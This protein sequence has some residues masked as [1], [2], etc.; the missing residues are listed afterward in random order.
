MPGSAQ[1]YVNGVAVAGALLLLMA[2]AEWPGHAESDFRQWVPYLL[3]AAFTSTL[4]VR[5]PGLAGSASP[6]FAVLLAAVASLSWA[7]TAPLAVVCG[8]VQCYWN[9]R[10]RP[11]ATQ[12]VFNAAAVVVSATIAFRFADWLVPAGSQYEPVARVA[13]ATPTLFAANTILVALLF[14]LLEGGSPLGFWRKINLWTFPH[15]VIGAVVTV[16]TA[17]ASHTSGLALPWLALPVLY[18]QHAFQRE[19]MG[20]I[21]N[22]GSTR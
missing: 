11:S 7:E 8:L 5:L 20:F 19:L 2:L 16:A 4:K 1:R 9:A 10:K 14:S 17:L 13:I 21:E 18:L 22:P 15:Y 12:L 3:L 6:G